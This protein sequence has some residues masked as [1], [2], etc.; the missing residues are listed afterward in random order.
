MKIDE[1]RNNPDL[2]NR[3]IADNTPLVKRAIRIYFRQVSKEKYEEY[4]QLGM[5]GMYKALLRFDSSLGYEF[6]TFAIP[7]I[8]GEI[9]HY[10][11]D[12]EKLIRQPRTIKV[13]YN[14]V[15]LN[16]PITDSGTFTLEDLLSEDSCFEER[17]EFKEKMHRLMSCLKPRELEVLRLRAM[18][19]SQAKIGKKIGIAQPS[20]GRILAKI[21]T[22]Y[23]AI[24]RE[25]N[26]AV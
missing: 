10:I 12:K 19:M 3:F 16:E 17:Y 6:S 8:A 11:R 2:L 5:I 20:V 14:I 25:Y 1:V 9:G 26:K 24:S 15:S 13:G 23:D 21:K 18:E 4:L 7:R 22:K